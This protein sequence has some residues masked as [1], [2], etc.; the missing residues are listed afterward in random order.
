MLP[1]LLDAVLHPDTAPIL[2]ESQY[3]GWWCSG[4]GGSTSPH[5][6]V[7]PPTSLPPM[8]CIPNPPPH[9]DDVASLPNRGPPCGGNLPEFD[10]SGGYYPCLQAKKHYCLHKRFLKYTRAL[11]FWPF[12]SQYSVHPIPLP[13]GLLQIRDYCQPFIV[14]N[15]QDP[16]KVFKRWFCGEWTPIVLE[17]RC[18]SYAGLL[19][20]P[21]LSL[22]FHSICAHICGSVAAVW[23]LPGD[24]NVLPESLW[25]GLAPLL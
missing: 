13:Q 11:V 10:Q 8:A 12:P 21:P 9:H 22:L 24:K 16:P 7:L 17:S 1:V 4:S 19:F 2:D 15:Y 25:V 18:C 20:K 3:I 5:P 23:G 6:L 14:R